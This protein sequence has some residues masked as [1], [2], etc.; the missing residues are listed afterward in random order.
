[1][2]EKILIIEDEKDVAESMRRK[3]SRANFESF[4]ASNGEEGL[5]LVKTMKPDLVITDIV[6]PEMDGYAFCQ[7]LKEIGTLAKI[8]IIILTAYANRI[9]DFND[10]GVQEF[11]V[12]PFDG[13]QL[14]GVIQR[15]LIMA[16]EKRPGKTILLQDGHEA[17]I[18]IALRKF[19]DWGY[20]ATVKVIEEGT[21]II[22]EAVRIQPDI[23]FLDASREIVPAHKIV[24]YLRSYV[25][26]RNTIVLIYMQDNN[27]EGNKKR[28]QH[29]HLEDIKQLCLGAGATKCIDSLNQ[30]S[31]LSVLFEFCK[32]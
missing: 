11:L 19:H 13:E 21:D 30:E 31:F 9:V 26:L 23:I 22:E 24:R 5:N 18:E 15:V 29:K 14:L 20:N 27:E 10:L 7:R 3:L 32:I 28:E 1:M 16:P 4:V 8:P 25:V 12:K 2:S 17:G 6:M